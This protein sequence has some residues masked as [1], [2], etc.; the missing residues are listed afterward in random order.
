MNSE[1]EIE[2]AVGTQGSEGKAEPVGQQTQGDSPT[3]TISTMRGLTLGAY[4]GGNAQYGLPAGLLTPPG[5]R[6]AGP[7]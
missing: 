6:M 2:L 4:I 7:W 5:L 1:N 3:R